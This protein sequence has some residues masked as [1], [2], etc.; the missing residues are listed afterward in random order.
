MYN[1]VLDLME[2]T[3]KKIVVT[4]GAGFL[5]SYIVEKLIKIGVNI[6]IMSHFSQMEGGNSKQQDHF[7][8]QTEQSHG[9]SF[10]GTGRSL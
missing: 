10:F 2:L 4:G 1:K 5:G 8:V 9:Y 6:F 7:L 3:D